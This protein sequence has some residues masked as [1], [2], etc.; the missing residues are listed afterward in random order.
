[1]EVVLR[2]L[3]QGPLL[4]V[5]SAGPAPKTTTAT[6]KADRRRVITE[7]TTAARILSW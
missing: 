6:T 3:W 4:F 1:M 7:A 5:L 2:S